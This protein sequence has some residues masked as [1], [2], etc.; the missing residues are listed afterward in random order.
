MSR[1]IDVTTA[2]RQFGTLLDEVYYKGD[3]ITIERKGKPLAQIVPFREDA[4]KSD[5]PSPEQQ[6]LLD[7]LHS[8]PVLTSQA[9]PTALLR[10]IRAEKRSRA[11]KQYGD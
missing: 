4:S 7:Q 1:V 9:D 10:K 11:N 5:D 6:A 8:L 3:I 2:R